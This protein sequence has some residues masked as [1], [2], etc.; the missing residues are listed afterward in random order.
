MAPTDPL[1]GAR[2][3]VAR[4]DPGSVLRRVDAALARGA[5]VNAGRAVALEQARRRRWA[6]EEQAVSRLPG[7]RRRTG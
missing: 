5:A 1:S 3:R 2:L 4:V 6:S 7:Q